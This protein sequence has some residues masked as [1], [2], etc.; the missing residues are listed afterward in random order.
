MYGELTYQFLIA[1]HQDDDSHRIIH[2]MPS[3]LS[4]KYQAP[5]AFSPFSLLHLILVHQQGYYCQTQPLSNLYIFYY[6]KGFF[7]F[8]QAKEKIFL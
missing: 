6:P 4:A 7:R 8:C 5:S 1:R 2:P 3:K